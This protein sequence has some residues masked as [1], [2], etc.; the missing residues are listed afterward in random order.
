LNKLFAP[1]LTL[2]EVVAQL[3]PIIK[4]YATE[5]S[6]GERFGDF[7]LRTVLAEKDAAS[8]VEAAS[9]AGACTI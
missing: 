4:R 5:R 8:A 1:S 9:V 7:C 3:A 6:E 2:D